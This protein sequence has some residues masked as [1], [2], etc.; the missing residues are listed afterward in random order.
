MQLFDFFLS[1]TCWSLR[2]E[3]SKKVHFRGGSS[4]LLLLWICFWVSDPQWRRYRKWITE[5]TVTNFSGRTGSFVVQSLSRLKTFK[6]INS[7]FTSKMET[8]FFHD[9]PSGRSQCNRGCVYMKFLLIEASFFFSKMQFYS[10]LFTG[11]CQK[12]ANF[13]I[14]C[15]PREL[16]TLFKLVKALQRWFNDSLGLFAAKRH[17]TRWNC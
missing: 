8:S 16:L 5:P 12:N 3:T 11:N 1:R 17:R 15:K 10:S 13:T 9:S 4:Y 14:L 6:Y 7:V 2:E